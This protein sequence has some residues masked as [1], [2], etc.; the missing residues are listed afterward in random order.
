[1]F[2]FFLVICLIAVLLYKLLPSFAG[3]NQEFFDIIIENTSRSGFNKSG[4]LN[5]F[6]LLLVVGGIMLLLLWAFSNRLS[7][8]SAGKFSAFSKSFDLSAPKAVPLCLLLF[9]AC[10][11]LANLIAF[12]KFIWP[13][14]F[15]V[16][17]CTA[18]CLL[19][20]SFT[21]KYHLNSETL[22]GILLVYVLTYYDI[23]AGCV[24]IAHFN[25]AFTINTMTHQLLALFIGTVILLLPVMAAHRKLLLL[26]LF[27]PFLFII[28]LVDTYR[29]QGADIRVPYAKG[30]YVF[31]YCLLLLSFFILSVHI[32]NNWNKPATISAPK[33]TPKGRLSSIISPLTPMIL[34]AFHSF[35]A[36][37]M[38]AQPDQHH[39]GEQMIPWTQVFSLGQSL[40]EEY[41]PV[42]G[43]FPFVNGFIQHKLLGG[44][45]SDYSPAIS[46]TM[47][48]FCF[49]TMFLITRL[50]GSSTAVL[51]AV[52]FALP[53]YNRQYLVLPVL[54]LLSM[55]ALQSR[56]L[57]WT[58]TWIFSCFLAGLYYPLYG[59]A[60]VIG[61]LPLGLYQLYL[62]I[63]TKEWKKD[64][65][66]PLSYLEFLLCFLPIACSIPLLFKILNHTLIYSSQTVL[67]DGINVFGQETP[68]SF[69]PYLESIPKLRN[70]CYFSLRMLLPM[71]GIW[72]FLFCMSR[73]FGTLKKSE[74]VRVLFLELFAGA[75]TLGI[76][77]SYTLVR[78][79][80]NCVLSRTAWIL[81][82]AAGI[83]LPVLLLSSIGNYSNLNM[84][85]IEHTDSIENTEHIKKEGPELKHPFRNLSTCI[86]LGLCISIPFWIFNEISREKTPPMWVYPDGE[87]LIAMDDSSKIFGEYVVPDSFVKSEDTGL[88]AKYQNL[89]GNGFMVADQL[90]YIEDY[91]AVIEKCEA[92]QGDV[93]YMALDGQGFYDYLG[94]KCSVTGY[95]PAAKSFEAQRE[96]WSQAEKNYPVIFNLNAQDSYYITRFMWDAG[97]VYC[98]EDSAFY[99]VNLFEAIY[100][101]EDPDDYR[102]YAASTEFGLSADSFGTS[103]EGLISIFDHSAIAMNQTVVDPDSELLQEK[104]TEPLPA[105]IEGN[106]YDFMYLSLDSTIPAD[107]TVTISWNDATGHSFDGARVTATVG[108]GTLLIPMGMNSCWLLSDISNF[109]LTI[110][111]SAGGLLYETDYKY[112]SENQISKAVTQ[113]SLLA[114]NYNR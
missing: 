28:W 84:E 1:M 23:A 78:A 114:L 43:L 71:I 11:F 3:G 21:E 45:V 32:K 16:L 12:Q 74:K 54:L 73:L 85:N 103:F 53:C 38:Y 30:Y 25:S 39:H 50:T 24:L 35:S 99:P 42:S 20:A 68:I 6:W 81:V 67:A 57:L 52:L 65:R 112:L 31:F 15:A 5:L 14:F 33:G 94:V 7:Q 77:Y 10:P 56:R 89:L 19:P 92:V 9:T 27:L 100:P 47:V 86:F 83:Y 66:S 70:F 18:F 37:A 41:T 26:Q 110:N 95:I 4:E 107:A 91:A 46:I 104:A 51:F 106:Q 90:H 8:S 98:A 69:M 72:A 60:L 96:I 64:L 75:T 48:I 2:S 109:T 113:F 36:C 63:K 34:F 17:L 58:Y 59:G 105:V 55:P 102:N 76:S 82:A 40:Y 49:L 79:D 87:S 111:D 108:E 101:E 44:T 22:P 97:Y 62:W 93:T 29:Y 88:P 13:L 80:T 61:T